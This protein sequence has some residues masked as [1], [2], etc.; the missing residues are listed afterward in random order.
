[1]DPSQSLNIEISKKKPSYPVKPLLAEYLKRYQ[2]YS[3][4]GLGYNDLTRWDT[5]FPVNDIEGNDTLWRSVL[6]S[7][8]EQDDIFIKLLHI[9]ANITADN[10]EGVVEHLKV[11][12]VDYCLFGNS[13]PFRIKIR[14]LLNDNYDYYYVK[15]A[16]ASRVYGLELEEM[17]SPNKI[18]YLCN[19]DTLVEQHISGIPGDQFLGNY[20]QDSGMNAVRLA[21]EFVKFNERCFV[22]LLGDMRAYNFVVD[23]TP[24]FDQMQYRIRAIDFDQQ[25]FEGN[26][27]IYLPQ[28]YKENTPYVQMALDLLGHNSRVQ[29]QKE[30]RTL[31]RRRVG[32][33]RYQLQRLIKVMRRDEISTPEKLKELKYQL[34]DYHNNKSYIRLKNMGAILFK[35]L[36]YILELNIS[37]MK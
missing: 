29:Y 32:A 4:F 34:A 17:L 26:C 8:Y 24:D 10:V 21:K 5:A 2:R 31:M 28:F 27:K 36:N 30:E 1:M 7:R 9:Y 35:Q 25:S 15:K 16:D 20:F 6:Y 22:R 3:L 13:N 19:E 23:V 37:P 11:E 33:N 12:S 14:N 18:F